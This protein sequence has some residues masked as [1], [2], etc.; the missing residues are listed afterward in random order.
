MGLIMLQQLLVSDNFWQGTAEFLIILL[1][2]G[3]A[4]HEIKPR[5]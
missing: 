2:L 5:K 3:F 4:I 1:I